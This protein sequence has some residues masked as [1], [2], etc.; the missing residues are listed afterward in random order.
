MPRVTHVPRRNLRPPR[1][2][3][4][5]SSGGSTRWRWAS[6]TSWSSSSRP[7]T[8]PPMSVTS[9]GVPLGGAVQ[10][11]G[12]LAGAVLRARVEV[13]RSGPPRGDLTRGGGPVLPDLGHEHGCQQLLAPD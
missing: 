11:R 2:G 10:L 1:A 6:S 7:R 9:S 12:V 5:W 13:A 8:D 3:A 4:A